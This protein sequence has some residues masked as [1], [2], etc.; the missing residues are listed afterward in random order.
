MECG[1][2]AALMA[3]GRE[4][5][6]AGSGRRETAVQ[7]I[8]RDLGGRARLPEIYAA[9]LGRRPTDNKHWQEKIRQVLQRGPFRNV[10]RG[11]WVV[12]E[13]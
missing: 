3:P 13:A 8:L 7:S 12:V 4:E 6:R 5:L 9:M 11:E 2:A 1:L 10:D